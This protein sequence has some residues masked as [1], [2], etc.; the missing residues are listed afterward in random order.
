SLSMGD[1]HL[2]TI[3]ATESD[4]FIKSCVEDLVPIPSESEGETGCDVPSCFTTFSNILFDADYDFDFV[5][6]QSLHNEDFSEKI[7]LNLLFEEE[8][9]SIKKNQH[10]FNAESDLVESMLNR[11]SSIISSSL[12]INSLLDEFVG[13]LTLLKSI[14]LGIDETNCHPENE[15]HLSQRLLYDNSSPRPPKEFNSENYNAK[16]ESFTPSPIPNEDRW[17][18]WI[19]RVGVG[20]AEIVVS[21]LLTSAF[22]PITSFELVVTPRMSSNLFVND[23]MLSS[24]GDSFLLATLFEISLASLEGFRESFKQAV[25]MGELTVGMGDSTVSVSI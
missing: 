24:D 5:D 13:E 6:D 14:P 7:F 11:D 17:S 8:I 20:L 3:P 18:L 23:R 19:L 12:K 21:I 16:I 10:H 25:G 2:D 1:E 9:S 4:E 22:T 15:I